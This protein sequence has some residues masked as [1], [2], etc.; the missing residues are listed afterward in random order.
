MPVEQRYTAFEKAKNYTKQYELDSIDSIVTRQE[1]GMLGYV[2]A[3]QFATTGSNIFEGGQIIDGNVTVTGDIYAANFV[4]S[5]T[6]LFTGSTNH[7]SHIED[8]HT[9]T[10]SVR[11]TGSLNVI[12][13]INGVINATN[14]VV[15][16]STQ[17]TAFGFVS[18]SYE[19]TGRGIVSSSLQI[20]SLLPI[21]IVSSSVQVL[22]GSGVV[23]GSYETTGRSIISSSTQITSFGFISSSQTI[24]TGSLA[25]TGSNTFIGNQTITGSFL[26]SGSTTQIGN[27]TLSGNTIMSGTLDVSGSTTFRGVHQLSGSNSILGNTI[28]SGSVSVSG[29]LDIHGSTN[30]HNHT[31]IM[32]G[33][34][35][36]TG[37]QVITGSLDIKGDVNIASGSSFYRWGN[38]LFNYGAFY[39]T[40]T[41]SGSANVSQS[42]QFNSTDY[43][44]G[45]T[46][47]NNTRIVLANVGVY[48]IQFSAQLVDTGAGDSIIHIWIKKN[49]QNVPNSAGR[50]FLQANKEVIASWNYVVPATSPNDYY[51]LVWQSTDADARI[52]YEAATGN[53]PA[54]P[55]IILTVTQVA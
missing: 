6:L 25:T 39:D 53:I 46:I 28:M 27:N 26:V 8:V 18:G 51:E 14:G 20:V 34:M 31:I 24:N 13:G 7:G 41:Q 29:A 22:G 30:F 10:G 16:S 21:G 23:S 36:T 48:N 1:D 9:Y 45:V 37:S 50:I 47:S 43:S 44:Q 42:I 17:I 40:R 19:T 55:S 54:I 52:L 49:G 11:I 12:G 5:S 4:T 3:G 32:T 2:S 38:K 33:S 35:Y 15:S